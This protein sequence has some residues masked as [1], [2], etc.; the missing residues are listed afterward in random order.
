MNI[1]EL[2][3]F[4]LSLP[5]VTEDVK[6]GNDLCFS[7]GGRMFCVTSLEGETGVSLKVRDEKFAELCE[8]EYI[9]IA[10]YVGRY[11]WISISNYSR[12]TNSEWKHYI[13]QSYEL[14]KEK[15]PKKIRDSIKVKKI[16]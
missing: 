8:T 13:R 3:S 11:K 9:C 10:A 7:I 4:C 15:L 1:E 16:C 6:W 2:R 12:F 5:G 14:I